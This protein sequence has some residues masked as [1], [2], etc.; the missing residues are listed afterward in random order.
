[1]KLAQLQKQL[2]LLVVNEEGNELTVSTKCVNNQCLQS[3]CMCSL[4]KHVAEKMTSLCAEGRFD[5]HHLMM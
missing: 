2:M 5:H 1:M 4:K 3:V